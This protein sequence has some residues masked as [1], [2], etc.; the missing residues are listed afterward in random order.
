MARQGNA[1]CIYTKGRVM[2][3]TLLESLQM[4]ASTYFE[5][6]KG[7]IFVFTGSLVTVQ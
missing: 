5:N 1:L 2:M 6:K 3:H 7:G 4:F